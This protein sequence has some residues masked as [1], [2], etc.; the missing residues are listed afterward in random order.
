MK[1]KALLIFICLLLMAG[2]AF[3]DSWTISSNYI[4]LNTAGTGGHTETFGT[5][6]SYDWLLNP[7]LTFAVE[8]IGSWDND[9]E[10]YGG[11]VNMKMHMGTWGEFDIYG[12]G[13]ADY[14]HARS[15]PS[16]HSED[17]FI[18]GPLVGARTP[19]NENTSL[20]AQYQYGFIDGATLRTAFDEAQWVVVGLEM[21]F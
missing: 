10:L 8:G 9:A 17:G 11:G 6:V 4:K 7:N 1:G 15:L 2:V 16:G 21:A 13:Y 3:G 19:L 14:V 18:Y 20:F 12:G 5:A